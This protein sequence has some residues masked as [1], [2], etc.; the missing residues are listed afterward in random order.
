MVA[1]LPLIPEHELQGQG[2]GLARHCIRSPG[3]CPYWLADPMPAHSPEAL[4]RCLRS[5]SRPSPHWPFPLLICSSQTP[6]NFCVLR[7]S[8]QS[9]P[10]NAEGNVPPLKVVSLT[11]SI[12]DTCVGSGRSQL[13]PPSLTQGRQVAQP[14]MPHSSWGCLPGPWVCHPSSELWPARQVWLF[15]G[16]A[17]V[18]SKLVNVVFSK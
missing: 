15:L 7:S 10:L 6:A 16:Y 17:G 2:P 3:P 14:T 9:F 4:A 1:C 13:P 5:Q 8:V 18:G 12:T 11:T